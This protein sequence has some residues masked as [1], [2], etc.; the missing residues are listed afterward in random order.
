MATTFHVTM[1]AENMEGKGVLIFLRPTSLPRDALVHAWQALIPSTGSTASFEYN[2]VISSHVFS[3]RDPSH[4]ILSDTNNVH[5]GSLLEAVSS[6]GLSPKLQMAPTSLAE[7]KLTPTQVGVINHTHPHVEL[8]CNW[9]VSG[10]PVVTVPNLGDGET[11]PFELEPNLYFMVARPPLVG[12]TYSPDNFAD[13][14][15][16]PAPAVDSEIYINVIEDQGRWQFVF[17]E[18]V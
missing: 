7:E 6:E 8:D 2:P 16:Y 3:R 18:R 11:C 10:R 14:T 1:N 5:P 9:L 12:E 17:N 4:Y 15:C 13:M